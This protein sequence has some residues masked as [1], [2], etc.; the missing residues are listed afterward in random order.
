M[1]CAVLAAWD[2]ALGFTSAI[3]WGG[4]ACMCCIHS[5]CLGLSD[6]PAAVALPALGQLPA[7]R[8]VEDL[9]PGIKLPFCGLVQLEV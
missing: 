6:G 8:A 3:E 7:M 1:L 5:H 4:H 2:Q 9:G